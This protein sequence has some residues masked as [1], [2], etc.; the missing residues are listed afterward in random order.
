MTRS[1]NTILIANRGEIACRIIETCK[2]LNIKTIAVYSQSDINALHVKNADVAHCIGSDNLQESYLNVD[3]II[4]VAKSEA[5]DA[6]HPGYGFLSE[7]TK[8]AN[9]CAH[10]NIVF[11]G[12][13]PEAIRAMAVKDEAKKLMSQAGV[14]VIPGALDLDNASV[15]KKH[16]EEI[17]LPVILKAACGGGGK[18]M[19]IIRDMNEIE[20]MVR[21]AQKEA[22]NAFGDSRLFLEKYLVNARHIEIQIFRDS[23]GNCVHLFERDCSTQRRHQKILEETPAINMLQQTKDKMYQS[24]IDAA[25]AIDYCGAGTIEF[26]LSNDNQ[27]YFMEM[28]T[29]LQVEHPVTE[30]TTDLDLVEWQIKVAAGEPLPLKQTDIKQT[31]HAIEARIYSEDPDQQFLPQTGTIKHIFY[32]ALTNTRLDSGIQAGDK[33]GIHFDP[34]L[35]KLIAWGPSRQKA[36]HLLLNSLSE[37]QIIGVKNNIPFLQALLKSPKFLEGL[38]VQYLEKHLS[39][40]INIKP[41]T[42]ILVLSLA[43]L[44]NITQRDTIPPST[45]PSPWD[46]KNAFRVN[47]PWQ[48]K[49][50]LCMQEETFSLQIEHIAQGLSTNKTTLTVTCLETSESLTLSGY[51][52]NNRLYYL[53]DNSWHTVP[54]AIDTQTVHF[55]LKG[56]LYSFKNNTQTSNAQQIEQHDGKHILAPMP[57]LITKIFKKDGESVEKGEK[58]IA[59]EAMKMEH[60]VAAPKAGK[61]KTIHFQMGEQVVE[62]STLLEYQ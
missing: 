24:A 18:G 35:C 53:F 14:P 48:E 30:M 29:R 3:K 37:F 12:P 59:L 50:L 46:K 58:L 52:E 20:E 23:L 10:N 47:L 22:L 25:N 16:C 1:I 15:I 2:R 61:I 42:S 32:K 31:G 38:D 62:G 27:F 6:I 9:A 54:C 39:P 33:I 34:M 11:I 45:P 7:N 44:I 57:G 28:N 49:I 56:Q 8:L 26:L 55:L 17:G 41:P 13:S 60:T 40:Y 19:R 36:I 51:L 43:A 4:D 5:V 21:Q